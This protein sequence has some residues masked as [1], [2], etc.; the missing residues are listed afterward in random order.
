[1]AADDTQ[2]DGPR[3]IAAFK[4]QYNRMPDMLSIDGYR[5]A[6]YDGGRISLTREANQCMTFIADGDELPNQYPTHQGRCK[7]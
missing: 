4:G 5:R 3:Q 7:S 1:M 6:G 2:D